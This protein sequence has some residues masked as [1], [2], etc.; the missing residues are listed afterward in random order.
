M[1]FG[2]NLGSCV[3]DKD[4]HHILKVN[5][6]LKGAVL[7]WLARHKAVFMRLGSEVTVSRNILTLSRAVG[8]RQARKPRLFLRLR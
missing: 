3:L 8:R 5:D 2:V 7:F 4:R 6:I 1:G